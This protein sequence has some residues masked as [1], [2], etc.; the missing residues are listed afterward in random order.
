MTFRNRQWRDPC[1]RCGRALH[2]PEGGD[3]KGYEVFDWETGE[4]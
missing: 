3:Q 1:H 4:S 2:V